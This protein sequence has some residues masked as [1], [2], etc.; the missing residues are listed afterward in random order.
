LLDKLG[1]AQI[2]ETFRK[3]M[4]KLLSVLDLAKEKTPSVRCDPPAVE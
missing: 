3:P 1:I 2:K 4:Q